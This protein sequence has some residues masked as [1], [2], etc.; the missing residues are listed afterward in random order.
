MS[1]LVEFLLARVAE[2]EAAARAASLGSETWHLGEYD[3]TVLWWQPSPPEK[4]A[5]VRRMFGDELAADHAR[6]AGQTI[7]VSGDKIAPHIARHDPARVLREC[8]AKRRIVEMH[9]PME[10]REPSNRLVGP[11]ASGYVRS[12]FD[13]G[14]MVV[15]D[16]CGPHE[17]VKWR[18][19]GKGNHPCPTLRAL[20][21]VYADHPDYRDEWRP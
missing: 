11:D 19:G 3:E 20:A 1:E 2:D 18:T 12:Q 9:S 16:E 7:E 14:I 4:I 6:W 17:D 10:V 21:A 13:P 5:A 15:C 8:E